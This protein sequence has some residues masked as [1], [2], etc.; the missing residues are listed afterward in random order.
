MSGRHLGRST[1]AQPPTLEPH[2]RPGA[3]IRR[4]ARAER[5]SPQFLPPRWLGGE[6]RA[7]RDGCLRA[8]V[9]LGPMEAQAFVDQPD[10]TSAGARTRPQPRSE[11]SDSI[12]RMRTTATVASSFRIP[13]ENSSIDRKI[14]L[15][16]FLAD[17]GRI[18]S[19]AF[20]KFW[21]PHS[22]PLGFIASTTS[23]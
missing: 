21:I 13:R 18:A 4:G 15:T 5:G 16:T 17:R 22:S 9:E 2:P 6:A 11:S 19:A 20:H 3:A 23:V 10:P 1:L 8:A 12:Y 14:V 7:A